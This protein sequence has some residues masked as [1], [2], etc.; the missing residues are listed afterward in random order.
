MR[1]K[2]T[3]MVKLGYNTMQLS[4][5]RQKGDRGRKVDNGK[6]LTKVLCSIGRQKTQLGVPLG[7]NGII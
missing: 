7:E 6:G 5:W 2:G 4:D 1:L 3:K